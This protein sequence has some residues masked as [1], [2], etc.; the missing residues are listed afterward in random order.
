MTD[1]AIK[2]VPNM[3]LNLSRRHAKAVQAYNK[4]HERTLV[5]IDDD[6]LGLLEGLHFE[7]SGVGNADTRARTLHELV[8]SRPPGFAIGAVDAIPTW[9][10]EARRADDEPVCGYLAVILKGKLKVFRVPH[11]VMRTIGVF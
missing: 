11:R 2:L 8:V 7:A 5:L 10:R 9:M 4:L 1:A 3:Y 6:N